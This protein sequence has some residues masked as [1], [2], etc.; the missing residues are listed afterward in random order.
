MYSGKQ[1]CR[2]R[3]YRKVHAHIG[4]RKSFKGI[5]Y[6]KESFG[7]VDDG[8]Y[9]LSVKDL[10]LK[11][12]GLGKIQGKKGINR[13]FGSREY[14]KAA[15]ELKRY[16]DMLQLESFIDPVGNVHGIYRTGKEPKKE[17]MIGS[18]LDTVKNGGMFDGLLGVAAELSCVQRLIMEKRN[19]GFDI[20]LVAS[21]GEEGNELGGTFGS[22]CMTGAIDI[23]D[24]EFIKRAEKYHISSKDIL[25]SKMDFSPVSCYLELH[26]KQGD[27]N[28]KDCNCD[29]GNSA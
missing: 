28:R 19:L 8:G 15:E 5:G 23:S 24:E 3:C 16:M 27:R 6:V 13:V 17:I 22:R 11:F 2:F 12:A 4:C 25:L 10:I 14:D 26:I 29:G 20:Y 21:N 7:C 9:M 1:R 18:H